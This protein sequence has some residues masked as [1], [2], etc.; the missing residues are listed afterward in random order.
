MSYERLPDWANRLNDY[1][2]KIRDK[3]FRFGKHDCAILVSG[4]VEAMTGENPMADIPPYKNWRDVK[5]FLKGSSFYKELQKR[6]GAPVNAAHGHQG[7]IAYHEKNLGIILGR[8][9]M[10]FGEN[11]YVFMP[12]SKVEKAFHVGKP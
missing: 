11:G 12:I 6:F 5:K 4:A 8:R 1:L 2:A 7:D 9:A 10:F 3:E